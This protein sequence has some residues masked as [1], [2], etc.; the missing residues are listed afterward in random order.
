M[1]TGSGNLYL[2]L[3]KTDVD[4]REAFL[5]PQ[6]V[7]AMSS[8]WEHLTGIPRD[9]METDRL[10]AALVMVGRPLEVDELW[11]RN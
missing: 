11:L 10:M 4:I 6:P 8:T 7:K 9:L 3:S 1:S 2:P 5:A